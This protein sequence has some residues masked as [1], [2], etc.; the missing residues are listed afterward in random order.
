MRA[1][2]QKEAETASSRTELRYVEGY[3][4]LGNTSALASPPVF[5]D[6]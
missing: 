3:A 1:G 4:K 2:G 6:P 5:D